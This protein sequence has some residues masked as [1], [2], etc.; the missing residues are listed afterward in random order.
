MD[1][2]VRLSRFYPSDSIISTKRI[3]SLAMEM[4]NKN[5]E[6]AKKI[7]KEFYSDITKVN[8]SKNPSEFVD[9]ISELAKRA[10]QGDKTVIDLISNA[11]VTDIVAE[12]GNLSE[13]EVYSLSKAIKIL[14]E[15][16]LRAIATENTSAN[17]IPYFM[18]LAPLIRFMYP[19]LVATQ[20]YDVRNMSTPGA[21]VYFFR[22]YEELTNSTNPYPFSSYLSVDMTTGRLLSGDSLGYYGTAP[23]QG[24]FVPATTSS[25]EEIIRGN[26]YNILRDASLLPPATVA[27]DNKLRVTPDFR[28][29]AVRITDG[30]TSGTINVS[31]NIESSGAITGAGTATIGANTYTV[32]VTGRVDFKSGDFTITVIV[33][34]GDAPEVQGIEVYARVAYESRDPARKLRLEL[35]RQTL[36]EN[37]LESTI[38]VSPEMTFDA[39][40]LFNLDILGEVSSI[41]SSIIALN[42]DAFLLMNLYNASLVH[43]IEESVDMTAAALAA[44]SW[45][46]GMYV[47]THFPYAISNLL[48]KIFR[49][50]PVPEVEP[51][52]VMNVEDASLLVNIG[53]W[54]SDPV[55]KAD[56]FKI[57]T[58]SKDGSE[59]W[60]K[61][62]PTPI[63]PV[64][65]NLLVLK[66]KQEFFS[67]AIYAPYATHMI[68]YPANTLGQAMTAVHRFGTSVIYPNVVGRLIV[69]R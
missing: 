51:I 68:P 37:R 63:L 60:I 28:V 31:S 66:S 43:N 25:A 24:V 32:N 12:Q 10:L 11:V 46:P 62:L 26:V 5:A 38:L 42:T 30:A 56:P 1:K 45:G 27:P 55:T 6:D 69:Q 54:V 48:G 67:T 19:R 17:V 47:M 65:R 18:Y 33:T 8:A 35:A 64:G 4:A 29:I 9:K 15:N 49:N 2:D 59:E 41:L 52:L 3:Y 7:V 58:R 36:A 44:Y 40:V 22:F 23:G 50:T 34:G 57:Y 16:S 14:Y 53:K 21:Y 61:V 20:V 13:A 39:Q